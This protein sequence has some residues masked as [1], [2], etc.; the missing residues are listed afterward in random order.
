MQYLLFSSKIVKDLCRLHPHPHRS[1]KNQGLVKSVSITSS[2]REHFGTILR[3]IKNVESLCNH[4]NKNLNAIQ[5]IQINISLFMQ[6]FF[7]Q[8]KHFLDIA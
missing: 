2:Q 5:R 1:N 6:S 7:L 4:I 8:K 3:G